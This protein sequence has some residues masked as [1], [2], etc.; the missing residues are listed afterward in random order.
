MSSTKIVIIVLVLVGLLFAIFVAAGALRRDPTLPPPEKIAD[1][2]TKDAPK[3]DWTKT[4]KNLFSSLQPKILKDKVYSSNTTDP[5]PAD[6]KQ[7]FR[8]ATFHLLSGSADISYKDETPQASDSPLK[9]M[10]NPQHFTLPQQDSNVSDQE[11]GSILVL[12]R[13]GTLTF[14][15]TNNSA[16]RVK[17]E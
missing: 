5:I 9:K 13:G 11:R 8:T 17:V 12:K 6:D 3:P 10:K 14:T 16:C 7:A 4:V 1:K 15:C 2:D